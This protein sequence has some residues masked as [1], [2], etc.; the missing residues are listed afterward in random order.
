MP[1]GRPV[2]S[3]TLGEGGDVTATLVSLGAS[4][5]ELLVVGGDGRRRDVVL[6]HATVADRLA[7]PYYLGG[8]I[9]RYANRIRDGHLV[10]GG[11]TWQLPTNDRGNTLH[12]GPDGFDRRLWSLED[13]T[14]DRA[15]FALTSPDG[16]M[17]FPGTVAAVASY[18]LVDAT[19]RIEYTAVTDATTVVNLTNHAYLNLAGHPGTVDDHWLQVS[20]RDYLPVDASGIPLGT[21]APVTGT[22]FDLSAA[23]RL[24]VV[25]R[26]PHPQVVAARG[27]DHN[28]VLDGGPAAVLACPAARLA[29][30]MTTTEPGLQV[31]TGNFL[32][33][34]MTAT[35]GSLLRQGDGIALE[36]QRF[37]DSP[38]HPEWPTALLEP[39]QEYRSSTELTF[40]DA[41]A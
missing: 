22:A 19:L 23:R 7:S 3:V 38:H 14:H 25:V 13:W 30:T 24:G 31:Y 39:G 28:Y 5:Q 33:G 21:A 12:G 37:P 18:T 29:M 34:S 11:R 10:V 16:D 9:G 1:D 27:I 17:G 4:L 41:S 6:A 15:T 26:Q 2:R 36:P 40:T 32:D 8:S 20:A 35:S